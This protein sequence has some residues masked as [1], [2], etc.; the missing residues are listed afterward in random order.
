P[1]YDVGARVDVDDQGALA[2]VRKQGGVSAGALK[3]LFRLVRDVARRARRADVIYANTQR[4]MVVAALAGRLARKPV[5]WHLRDIVSDAHF[6][7]KQLLAIKHCVRFGVTRV[8]ANSDASAQAFR[9]LTGFTPQHVDVVF[10]GI[11]AE[12]FDALAGVSQAVLRARFGLP[13]H[14]WLVGSFSRL[15]RWKGQHVLLEAA[16]SHPDMHVVLVGA[17]LFGED[18][19]AAQLHEYV[20][21]HGMD[22]RVHFLGFQRDVAACMKAV[23]VVAHTSI[24]P[25]PFGR[26]IV[27]GMLARRPVVAARAGGVIEIIEHDDNG[28]LCEPGAAHALGAALTAL[29][30]DR[31]LRERLV[32]SGHVTALRR[33]GTKTY[34]ERVEKIL[35]DTARAAKKR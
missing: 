25:E 34:V 14:A 7:R 22:E 17:P 16:A 28:L 27:E 35:A 10:N 19:Y 30:T 1:L 24:T 6:G 2:G 33:F 4:A 9:A 13:E 29:Q 20:T 26:V 15:A 21:R 11:S 32:A 12:P 8:I 23:D 31:A 18:D 3:Q 5:V